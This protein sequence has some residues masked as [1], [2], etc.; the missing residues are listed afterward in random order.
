MEG[1]GV[2]GRSPGLQ[3][4]LE[5]GKWGPR[6]EDARVLCSPPGTHPQRSVHFKASVP[7][8]FVC[9]QSGS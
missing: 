5:S 3:K 4:L 8:R 7:K 6:C 9:A 2:Q 1:G